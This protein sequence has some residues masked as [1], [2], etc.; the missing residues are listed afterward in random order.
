MLTATVDKT[1]FQPHA[2][3]GTNFINILSLLIYSDQDPPQ[4]QG[5][6]RSVGIQ[7]KPGLCHQRGLGTTT[8]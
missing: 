8:E 5:Q 2:S 1:G 3:I 7:T 4:S 6:G